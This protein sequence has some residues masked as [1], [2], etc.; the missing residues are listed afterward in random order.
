MPRALAPRSDPAPEGQFCGAPLGG[1]RAVRNKRPP[2]RARALPIA[3]PNI[4]TCGAGRVRR[5]SA[6]ARWAFFRTRRHLG[7]A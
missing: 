5:F 7:L 4:A 6:A 3:L 2:L 1:R